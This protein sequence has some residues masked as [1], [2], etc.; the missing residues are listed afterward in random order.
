M[1]RCHALLARAAARAGAVVQVGPAGPVDA[2]TPDAGTAVGGMVLV[3]ATLALLPLCA[4]FVRSISPARRIFFARWG[5]SHVALVAAVFLAANIV[6]SPV[7]MLLMDAGYERVFAGLCAM[8]LVF[9]VV[10]PLICW[11]ALRLDPEGVVCLGFRPDGQLRSGAAGVLAYAMMVPGFFGLAMVWPWL[12]GV[13]ELEFEAQEVA[14]GMSRLSG[15]QLA[16]AVPLAVVVLPFFEE[17]LFRG[18][19]QPLLVQNLGD[20]GGV[21]L[22]SAVFGAMHGVSAFLPIFGLS[23]I[24]GGVMLRTQRLFGPVL[25]HALHNGAMLVFLFVGTRLSEE[26]GYELEALRVLLP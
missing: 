26:L 15:L 7:A 22:T 21:V 4:F 12:M 25:I 2:F 10:A 17:L 18:F 1:S 16:L 5:F 6:F 24:L 3:A 19:L 20:R 9:G 11:L 14:V 13:L 23:L 8:V